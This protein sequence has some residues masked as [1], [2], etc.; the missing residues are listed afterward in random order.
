MAA[1]T[2]AGSMLPVLAG[3]TTMNISSVGTGSMT[4]VIDTGLLEGDEPPPP[5]RIAVTVVVDV[6]TTCMCMYACMC[7]SWCDMF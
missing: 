1:P 2:A 7:M 5:Q 3:F 4:M 6:M